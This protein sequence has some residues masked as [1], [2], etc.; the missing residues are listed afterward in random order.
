M[1]SK[2]CHDEGCSLKNVCLMW[3]NPSKAKICPCHE[4]LVKATCGGKKFCEPRLV[5]YHSLD[6]FKKLTKTNNSKVK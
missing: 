2:Y 1:H 3:H 6:E 4:C 5:L